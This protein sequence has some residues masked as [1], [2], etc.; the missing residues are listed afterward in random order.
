MVSV[1]K[2]CQYLQ[3]SRFDKFLYKANFHLK[4]CIMRYIYSNLYTGISNT[5][6]Q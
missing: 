3:F 4:L 2:N 5:V 6:E 1:N